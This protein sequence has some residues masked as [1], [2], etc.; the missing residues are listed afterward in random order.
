MGG[1]ALGGEQLLLP[2]TLH[3]GVSSVIIPFGG[4]SWAG[5]RAFI[6]SPSK[7]DSAQN[8]LIYC[9]SSAQNCYPEEKAVAGQRAC[10]TM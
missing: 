3:V 4:S 1:A 2:F 6:W 5:L 7:V 8:N 9:L 10:D